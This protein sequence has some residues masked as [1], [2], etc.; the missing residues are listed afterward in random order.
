MIGFERGL[1]DQCVD[2]LQ[3][4]RRAL[5]AGADPA[6]AEYPLGV[7]LAR[8]LITG[9]QH[10]AGCYYGF[11][12]GQA[13]GGIRIG[14]GR[15][16]QQL[17][18]E[19]FDIKEFSEDHLAR[20][21]TMFRYG[22]NRLLAAGRRV[23]DA[24]ENLIVFGRHP[25]IMPQDGRQVRAML[26][27]SAELAAIRRGLDVLAACYGRP[28]GRLGQMAAHKAPSMLDRP[29]GLAARR[30]VPAAVASAAKPHNP[31]ADSLF[32]PARKILFTD[33]AK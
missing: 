8:H 11:L 26:D 2:E 17:A 33:T 16:Y 4:R 6:L 21:E 32:S 24:T 9:E 18:A 25:G 27:V 19:A 12:Y 30:A 23:C 7:L 28:A 15:L 5:S 22:K 13:I 20:I 10:E 14:C 31:G 1:R 3:A 29:A